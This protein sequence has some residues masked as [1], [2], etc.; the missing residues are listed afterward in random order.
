MVER[1]PGG[2][3]PESRALPRGPRIL[4]YHSIDAQPGPDPHSLRVH[5][6]TLDRQLRHLRRRGLRGVSVAEWLEAARRGAASRMVALTFDDGY[7]DFVEKAMPVLAKHRMTATVYVVAG[8]VDGTSDWVEGGPHAPLMDADEIRAAHAAGHEVAS[9]TLTH[10]RVDLL[11]PAELE[12]EI[13]ESKAILE[14]ILQAPVTGLAYPYGAFN[15]AAVSA[16]RR[17]G[18]DY[19]CATDDHS[20][21]DA[22]SIARIFIGQRDGALRLEV[23]LLRHRARGRSGAAEGASGPVM[24]FVVAADRRIRRR[25]APPPYMPDTTSESTSR[26]RPE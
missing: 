2:G 21:R 9:H 17:A 24:R 23:K 16:V 5:P 14:E 26:P 7:R 3:R 12:R 22:F 8:K 18:Y 15:E 6:E 25:G 11:A 13:T 10:P 4:M 1:S 20:R 19:A